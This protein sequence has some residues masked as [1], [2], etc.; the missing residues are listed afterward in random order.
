[1]MRILQRIITCRIIVLKKTLL[2]LSVILNIK[3]AGYTDKKN[4]IFRISKSAVLYIAPT[5]SRGD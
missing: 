2:F 4:Y 3:I 1:M 5:D